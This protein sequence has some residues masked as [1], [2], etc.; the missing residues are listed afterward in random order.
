MKRED[1]CFVDG[2]TSHPFVSQITTGEVSSR[3]KCVRQQVTMRNR[4]AT[5]QVVLTIAK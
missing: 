4:T 5:G 2:C 3:V 1:Y